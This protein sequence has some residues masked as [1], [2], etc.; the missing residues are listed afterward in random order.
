MFMVASFVNMAFNSKKLRHKHLKV[1]QRKLDRA[2]RFLHLAT[3]QETI[4]RALDFLLHEE[5]VKKALD[6]AGG[7]GGFADAF[8]D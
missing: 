8:A 3:E 6:R 5:R 2:R 4:D 1:D 7:I